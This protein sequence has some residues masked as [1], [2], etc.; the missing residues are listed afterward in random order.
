MKASHIAAL[1]TVN[2]I[3]LG[4]AWIIVADF[5]RKVASWIVIIACLIWI[6]G[7]SYARVAR[8]G[9]PVARPLFF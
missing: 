7:A 4:L 3:V 8:Q 2:I 5:G 9:L 1:V 6:V